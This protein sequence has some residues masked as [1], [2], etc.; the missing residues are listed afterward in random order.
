MDIDCI[1]G[2]VALFVD[3]IPGPNWPVGNDEWRALIGEAL[4]RKG[5]LARSR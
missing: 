5:L 2:H 4:A 3:G 1:C